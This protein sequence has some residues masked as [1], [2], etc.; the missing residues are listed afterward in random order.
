MEEQI[1]RPGTLGHLL[2]VATL[3]DVTIATVPGWYTGICYVIALFGLYLAIAFGSWHFA[4]LL[5]AAA[6]G[7]YWVKLRSGLKLLRFLEKHPT[8]WKRYSKIPLDELEKTNLH[9]TLESLDA[10]KFRPEMLDE[11]FDHESLYGRAVPLSGE[12]ALA[13][14]LESWDSS[15]FFCGPSRTG[16]TTAAQQ[17]FKRLQPFYYSLKPDYV[18]ANCIGVQGNL[19]RPELLLDWLK[20]FHDEFRYR[21]ANRLTEEPELWVSIDELETNL[22]LIESRDRQLPKDEPK[23]APQILSMINEVLKLGNA[24]KVRLALVTQSFLSKNTRLDT[25]SMDGLSWL[26][27]GSELGGFKAFQSDRVKSR[28][29]PEVRGQIALMIEHPEGVKG[30][31]WLMELKGR[32]QLVAAAAPLHPDDLVQVQP[33]NPNAHPFRGRV[34]T[35]PVRIPTQ[36]AAPTQPASHG[37][38][39]GTKGLGVVRDRL[40]V[41]VDAIEEPETD[42]VR[43]ERFIKSL[44]HPQN[45]IAKYIVQKGRTVATADI[46]N[47]AKN[48]RGNPLSADEVEDALADMMRDYLIET[49]V[50]TGS[51]AEHVTWLGENP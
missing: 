26:I 30:F 38:K 35:A 12:E 50:P 20:P 31:W 41:A 49:Y 27:C 24:H 1:Y 18:P 48:L 7:L 4:V 3:N 22:E 19:E 45:L 16:K 37:F 34:T 9:E 36:T 33:F 43:Q 51:K 40:R 47:W 29:T 5:F 23:V 15:L 25:S 39:A 21:V 46:K 10:R 2:R 28:V 14:H 11:D 42:E 44:P 8:A 17:Y 6:V 13:Q 32:F